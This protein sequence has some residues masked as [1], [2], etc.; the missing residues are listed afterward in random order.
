MNAHD[1][2]CHP[3][4]MLN[5]R[6]VRYADGE[7]PEP[8]PVER[9]S[10]VRHGCFT[11]PVCTRSQGGTRKNGALSLPG[12]IIFHTQIETIYGTPRKRRHP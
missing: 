6:G 12:V 11:V 7:N 5:E 4:P 3:L 2:A 8:L 10:P 1:Y 9:V